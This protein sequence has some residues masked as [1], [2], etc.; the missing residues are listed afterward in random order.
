[1]LLF[2]NSSAHGPQPTSW[3]EKLEIEDLVVHLLCD[4][5]LLFLVPFEVEGLAVSNVHSENSVHDTLH[6]LMPLLLSSS[7]ILTDSSIASLIGK[8]THSI[9]PEADLRLPLAR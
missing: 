8:L 9:K 7:A 6:R 3:R 1:M 5:G 4:L 2:S